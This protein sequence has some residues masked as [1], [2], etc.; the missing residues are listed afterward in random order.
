MPEWS[1]LRNCRVA[2]LDTGLFPVREYEA[3]QFRHYGLDPLQLHGG[4]PE[5]V[6]GRA[7]DHDALIIVSSALPASVIEALRRCRVIS[8]RGIGTDKIDVEAASHAGILVTNVP[9]FCSNEMA[10]HAMALLLSLTRRIPRMSQLMAAGAWH[11]GRQEALTNRRLAGRILGLIGFG[12][13]AQ[14]VARR[15]KAFGMRLVATRRHLDA[16]C[17]EADELGV[18]MVGLD[19]LLRMSDYVSLHVP[20]VPATYHLLDDAKLRLMK[21]SAFL[22]NTARGAIVDEIALAAA[23]REERLAGAGIDTYEG[24][25]VFSDQEGPPD[26]PFM[27]LDNVIL[28]PHIGGES[29]EAQREVANGSIENLV[30]V[31]SGHWPHPGNIVNPGVEPRVALAAHDPSLPKDWLGEVFRGERG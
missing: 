8:R 25:E 22:I 26:H 19:A 7:V 16:P 3:S 23:L 29:A 2:R 31:L 9:G 21:P 10:E 30:A 4:T 20:L 12:K 28:T 1:S 11:R 27:G 15:A 13:S 6:I 5:E 24:I 14:A 17:P 18:Q